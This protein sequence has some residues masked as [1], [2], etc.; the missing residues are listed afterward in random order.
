MLYEEEWYLLMNILDVQNVHDEILV[1]QQ[2]RLDNGETVERIK[3]P[4]KAVGICHDPVNDVV[5]LIKDYSYGSMM[6]AKHLPTATLNEHQSSH[7]ALQ[8]AIESSTGALVKSVSYV[9]SYMEA[10]EYSYAPTQVYY[11]TFDSR[12]VLD[13]EDVVLTTGKLLFEAVNAGEHNDMN[14]IYASHYL[15]MLHNNL[16]K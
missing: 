7:V 15:K 3:Q 13:N 9:T 8:K 11:V 10:P 12:S 2:L 1:V 5:M 4:A 6:E 14:V 16:I